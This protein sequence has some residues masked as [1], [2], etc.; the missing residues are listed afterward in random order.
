MESLIRER[1]IAGVLDIT[2]TE[3]ADE[4]VGGTLSA[5]PSRLTAAAECG[6]PQI[7][8]VGALDMVNFGPLES[9]PNEFR[10]RRLHRHNDNITLMRTTPEENWQLGEEIAEKISKSAGPAAVL[11]PLQGV[12]AIDC[13][14]QP[15]DDPAARAA[16]FDGIR[17]RLAA[18]RPNSTTA[19]AVRPQVE[20]IELNCHINDTVFAEKAARSLLQLIRMQPQAAN[21]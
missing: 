21:H 8:S 7:V 10:G 19:G 15:F 18:I 5:G 16:L 14:G 4:L 11:L 2:T 3:L 9:V 1:L 12:S 17:S 13:A 20:L 6:V